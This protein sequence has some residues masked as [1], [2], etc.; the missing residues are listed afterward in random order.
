MGVRGREQRMEADGSTYVGESRIHIQSIICTHECM[1]TWDI[2]VYSCI[3]VSEHTI[4]IVNTPKHQTDR[5]TETDSDTNRQRDRQTER[6]T[7]RQY[8]FLK[9][10]LSVLWRASNLYSL[11]VFLSFLYG[12]STNN[13]VCFPGHH[14]AL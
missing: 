7:V 6:Q 10:C 4:I 3:D 8:A 12:L 14:S 1:C 11:K 9:M 13:T 5:Q 2:L